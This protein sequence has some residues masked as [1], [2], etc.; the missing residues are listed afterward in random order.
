MNRILPGVGRKNP[1]I[2]E[3]S[4]VF[5]TRENFYR[6]KWYFFI[7]MFCTRCGAK[8]PEDAFFCSRCGTALIR[9][10]PQQ[11]KSQQIQ[12]QQVKPQQIQHQQIQPQQIQSQQVRPQQ[13][14]R[15]QIEPQQ[16][17]Q[18]RIAS[19]GARVGALYGY[20]KRPAHPFLL[21]YEL[22]FSVFFAVLFT[23]MISRY[24]LHG[25]MSTA[26]TA[27]SLVILFMI[28]FGFFHYGKVLMK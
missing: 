7:V 23:M 5:F 4:G 21:L 25:N 15:Q 19:L 27:V 18:P 6:L 13:I 10:P 28:F 2:R 3:I 12:H 11:I 14:A 26:L 17:T 24:I 1:D 16:P 9:S 8:N 22:V 20:I